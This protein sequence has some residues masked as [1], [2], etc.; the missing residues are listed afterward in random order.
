M[1]SKSLDVEIWTELGV[2]Y[3]FVIG[4]I[5]AR[6]KMVGVRN[7]RPDDYLV[8]LMIVGKVGISYE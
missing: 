2:G 4:R 8:M 3:L 6:W 7:F 1:S 5:I